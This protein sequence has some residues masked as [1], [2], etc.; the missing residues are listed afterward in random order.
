MSVTDTV[1][2]PHSNSRVNFLNPDYFVVT[3]DPNEDWI[4]DEMLLE[5]D[6]DDHPDEL[7]VPKADQAT[8]DRTPAS[9]V[10]A[11]TTNIVARFAGSVATPGDRA[12][13]I[14]ACV[15]AVGAHLGPSSSL[16]YNGRKIYPT[17]YSAI[18]GQ[19]ST[20]GDWYRWFNHLR[21]PPSVIRSGIFKAESLVYLVRDS[22][23]RPDK[24]FTGK[25]EDPKWRTTK[26]DAGVADKRHLIM[27][28]M[29]PLL[30]SKTS[31]AAKRLLDTLNVAYDEGEVTAYVGYRD[32]GFHG[33][34]AAHIA[35]LIPEP[36]EKIAAAIWERMPG[37]LLAR[38]EGPSI[39]PDS[40]SDIWNLLSDI[41]IAIQ[42]APSEVTVAPSAKSIL[43][44][45]ARSQ[46]PYAVLTLLRL[47]HI[48][49]V[50]EC[51]PIVTES[52]LIQARAIVQASESTY[53]QLCDWNSALLTEKILR[54][55][56]TKGGV[57]S[58]DEIG[59]RFRRK[60]KDGQ[61]KINSALAELE[62]AQRLLRV[63]VKTD[64]RAREEWRIPKVS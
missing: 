19:A 42:K 62:L 52:L 40:G 39:D 27:Q 21:K 32:G 3:D 63:L 56:I 64:G 41:Q 9:F 24:V 7:A 8:E 35:L 48:L 10:N 55:V 50:L 6:T 61:A 18:V 34:K 17:L 30:A 33:T 20:V 25:G 15:T 46:R 54:F 60:S 13:A 31:A 4:D 16:I 2:T 45:E 38:G 44:P 12:A 36:N 1:I 47:A 22:V 28:A 11:D 59:D 58:K 49:A 53:H 57:C 43:E 23:L 37:L 14:L 51:S 29:G 5:P 26:V